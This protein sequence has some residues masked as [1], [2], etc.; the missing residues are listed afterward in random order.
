MSVFSVLFFS[1]ILDRS[2]RRLIG[3][4]DV[5]SD[6]FL[7][8]LGIIIIRVILSVVMFLADALGSPAADTV[9]SGCHSPPA[10]YYGYSFI[11]ID[12]YATASIRTKT[13]PSPIN[14]GSLC[15]HRHS[16]CFSPH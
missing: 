16:T 10:T 6:G 5:G 14:L 13:I 15:T 4:W 7:P 9:C 1:N 12:H 11:H 2:G 3:L 8:G